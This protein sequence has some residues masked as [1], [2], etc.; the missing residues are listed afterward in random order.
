MDSS[1]NLISSTVIDGL[2]WATVTQSTIFYARVCDAFPGLR[3]IEKFSEEAAINRLSILLRP[4]LSVDLS[5]SSLGGQINPLWWTRGR[6]DMHVHSYEF[7]GKG[8][9]LINNLEFHVEHIVAVR[10]FGTEERDFVYIQTLLEKLT[11]LYHYQENW[12]DNYLQDR[13]KGYGNFQMIT[14]VSSVDRLKGELQKTTVL[15]ANCH[16]RIIAQ[17]RGWFRSK[18][19]R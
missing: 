14:R 6:V 2:N 16:R 9:V 1:L 3:G 5:S 13:R 12:L 4:P 10:A 17:E 7:L 18:R 8:G 19:G 15:C 11:G